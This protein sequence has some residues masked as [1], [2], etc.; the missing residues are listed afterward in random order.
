MRAAYF[1]GVSLAYHGHQAEFPCKEEEVVL[2]VRL[3]GICETD[4]Q[5]VRGYLGFRGTPGHEFVA[6]TEDGQRV[7]AEINA[8]CGHCP[9]CLAG[10]RNHCPHRTV[11]GIFGRAG[12]FAEKVA[13]P[14]SCIHRIPDEL[15]DEEA[16]FIEPLAAAFRV[17]EQVQVS[18][19]DK[20]AVL[21]DGKLGLLTVWVLRAAGAHVTWIGKHRSKLELGGEDVETALRE[22]TQALAKSFR[23][24]VDATGSSS[25]LEMALN[26]VRPSG[27]VVLKTTV[28]TPYQID[29][30]SVVIHEVRVLGS[31]CGPFPKAI[32]A[33]RSR[34]FDVTQLIEK[35]YPL[36]Q[37][38]EAFS[39][40]GK[41]GARKILLKIQ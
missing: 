10:Q 22:E 18:R 38:V 20:V 4:L 16:V 5:I 2:R 34:Q 19:G 41:P 9:T 1:D 12:A 40:A 37:V 15:S 11:L 13:V 24:V 17:T 6:E 35:V 3:A 32:E 25:G 39:H 27:T 23:L 26:L 14:S 31:R 29:L 8:S 7:T 28:A 21:G 33:L 30:A 36:E